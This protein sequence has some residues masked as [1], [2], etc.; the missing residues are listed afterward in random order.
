METPDPQLL[1]SLALVTS[2]MTEM[3]T[4]LTEIKCMKE[5]I[6]YIRKTVKWK[7]VKIQVHKE[8]SCCGRP[9]SGE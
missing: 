5:D 3:K 6:R 2:V 7:E 8:E 4:L 9:L 1:E